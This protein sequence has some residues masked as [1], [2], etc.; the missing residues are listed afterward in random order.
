M[1]T[2]KL[3]ETHGA[4]CT[5]T[6]STMR[7]V[8]FR[9][10]LIGDYRDISV[11]WISSMFKMEA[12]DRETLNHPYEHILKDGGVILFVESEDLGVVGVCGLKRT[13]SGSMELTKMGVRERARGRKAGEFLLAEMIKRAEALGADPLYL[14]TNSR[15]EAAIHLYEKAG[16]QHDAEIMALYGARYDRCDV[17]MRFA[18]GPNGRAERS[19]A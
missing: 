15:S 3:P 9:D 5:R 13:G 4:P 18:P 1:S 7:I 19:S 2:A 11:E 16:F 10:D 14:L 17:A 6:N 8:E 12:A